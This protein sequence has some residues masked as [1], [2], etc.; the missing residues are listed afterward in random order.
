[1]DWKHLFGGG[2][3][4]KKGEKKPEFGLKEIGIPKLLVILGC[5][6]FLLFSSLP[7]QEEKQLKEVEE[8]LNG[9]GEETDYEAYV[10][11]LEN[12]LSGLLRQVEGIGKAK[13]MITLKSTR[14]RVVLKDNPGSEESSSEEDGSG[15][16][17]ESSSFTKEE[18]TILVEG[19]DG[20]SIPYII[21]E[22][23]P[24]IEGV[25]VLCEGGGSSKTNTEIIEAVQV[26]FNLPSHK[27]KIM[28]LS[29]TD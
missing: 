3:K 28:K 7:E 11:S 14:E 1:M 26:L 6:L 5:G 23:E 2:T 9:S 20:N 15:G 12:K 13:V 19:E 4:E 25:V 21:K 29:Q 17:R 8:D 16:K 10:Q 24:Q 22:V 18:E 27:I